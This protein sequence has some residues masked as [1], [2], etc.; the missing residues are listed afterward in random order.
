MIQCKA[1]TRILYLAEANRPAGEK[2]V[3]STRTQEEQDRLDKAKFE[4]T[5]KL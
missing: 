4:K 5:R 2:G 3:K 1:C